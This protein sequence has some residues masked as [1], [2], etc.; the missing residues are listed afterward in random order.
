LGV[1]FPKIFGETIFCR[2]MLAENEFSI[3]EE[4]VDEETEEKV[5]ETFILL[6]FIVQIVLKDILV[7]KNTLSCRS[8]SL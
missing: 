3:E 7:H 5:R 4:E 1:N 8:L 2:K 6:Y